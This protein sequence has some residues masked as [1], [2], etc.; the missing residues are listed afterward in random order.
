MGSLMHALHCKNASEIHSKILA[1]RVYELKET[2]KGVDLM[3]REMEKLY[4]DGMELGELKAKREAAVS[5]AEDG[6]AIEK[7][8]RL[9]KVSVEEVRQWLDEVHVI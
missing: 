8:A 1:E 7:I 4:N 3:C 6:M 2:Q 5:M 9:I